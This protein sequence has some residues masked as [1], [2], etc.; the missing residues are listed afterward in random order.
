M[1]KRTTPLDLG[2]LE[3]S[4]LI[5]GDFEIEIYHYP[6]RLTTHISTDQAK[7]LINFL[8]EQIGE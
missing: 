7:E 6:N 3:V 5:D 1:S 8:Q 4:E 2:A